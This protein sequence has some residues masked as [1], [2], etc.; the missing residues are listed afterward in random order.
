MLPVTSLLTGG[1]VAILVW[2]SL[3]VSLRRILVKASLG[4]GGDETLIRRIRA[5]AN[6]VEYAP[7]GLIALAL[8][9]YRGASTVTALGIGAALVLGRLVHAAGMLAGILPLRSIG[10]ILTYISLL[11]SASWLVFGPVL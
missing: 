6:F 10:M 7:M 9:E 2:L 4:D 8:V 3:L 11:T 5:Q 1:L